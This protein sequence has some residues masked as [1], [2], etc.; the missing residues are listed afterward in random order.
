M[1][2]NILECQ[3]LIIEE[4]FNEAF[5]VE[6]YFILDQSTNTHIKDY[7]WTREE[8]YMISHISYDNQGLQTDFNFVLLKIISYIAHFHLNNKCHG[9]IGA[10]DIYLNNSIVT[11]NIYFVIDMDCSE[12]E[13]EIQSKHLCSQSLDSEEDSKSG[14]KQNPISKWGL[15]RKDK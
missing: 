12:L 10:Q 2:T 6:E 8:L 11:S 9:N 4:S 13:D 7:F 15:F 3:R 14:K 5:T 1:L